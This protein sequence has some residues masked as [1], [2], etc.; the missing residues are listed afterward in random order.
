MSRTRVSA[1]ARTFYTRARI[2]RRDLADRRFVSKLGYDE[3]A[4]KLLLSPHFDDAVLD[5]W[6]E[7]CAPGELAVVN[8]FGGV[9]EGGLVTLWDSI[10]GARDSAARVRERVAEDAAALARASREPHNLTLLDAQYSRPR[11]VRLEDLD[12]LLVAE[13]PR[14]SRVHTTA[15]IGGHPDHLLARRYALALRAKGM[16][17]T[18]HADLPYCVYH[19]WPHWVDGREPEPNR[20]IDPFWAQFFQGVAEMPA[21]R[22]AR[23][24]RLDDEAARAKL[25]AMSTYATQFPALSFGGREMLADPEIHRYEVCWDLD[26]RGARAAQAERSA[27]A[28]EATR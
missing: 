15:G 10:T 16:P 21:L 11:P 26:L 9:P 20:N 13:V 27:Q 7:L 17:V 23:V 5:C 3:A 8:V 12:T 18:L 6:S 19:G 28:R 25:D 24:R 1:V 4:P 22:D 2:V 14:A